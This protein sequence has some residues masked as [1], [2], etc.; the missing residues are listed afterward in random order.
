MINII[1]RH[2]NHIKPDPLYQAECLNCG[3]I[4]TF[5]QSDC[6]K[7]GGMDSHFWTWGVRCPVCRETIN[8]DFCACE[9]KPW[10]RLSE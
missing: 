9:H 8:Q 5:N 1:E 10:K 3:S 7:T 2:T 4:I 6:H